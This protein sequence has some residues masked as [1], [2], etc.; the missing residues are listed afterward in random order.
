VDRRKLRPGFSTSSGTRPTLVEVATNAD[1][2]ICGTCTID[3]PQSGLLNYRTLQ[4]HRGQLGCKRL[5]LTHIGA[6]MHNRL[7]E[8]T[9]EV[10]GDGLVITLGER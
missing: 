4:E 6:Q 10:A 3:G 2:F 9:E 1:L 5:V 8:V 7:A